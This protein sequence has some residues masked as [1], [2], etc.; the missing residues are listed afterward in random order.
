M[1]DGTI[2]SSYPRCDLSVKG[3]V[4]GENVHRPTRTELYVAPMLR[5]ALTAMFEQP[6]CMTA[7][8]AVMHRAGSDKL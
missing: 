4:R 5:F 8:R 2:C 1:L 3:A 7:I 6:Q